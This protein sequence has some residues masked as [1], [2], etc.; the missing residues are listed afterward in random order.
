[1]GHYVKFDTAGVLGDRRQILAHLDPHLAPEFGAA[2]SLR[3]AERCGRGGGER[4]ERAI[5]N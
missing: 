1:M 3:L 5:E 4:K 2:V